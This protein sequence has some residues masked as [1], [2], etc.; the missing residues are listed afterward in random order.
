MTSA[1]PLLRRLVNY[2]WA[3]FEQR[4]ARAYVAG[5]DREQALRV[6]E[7]LQQRAGGTV[8]LWNSGEQ[9]PVEIARECRST[10]DAIR[11][12]SLDC[13]LSIKAPALGF[14]RL[15]VATIVAEGQRAR[16]PIHFDA[17]RWELADRTFS[18]ISEVA[19][20]GSQ[21]GCTLPGRWRRSVSDSRLASELGLRVRVVK[22]QSPDGERSSV[23]A[24][25]G[26]L[27]V[28]DALAG[29]VPLV[30]V[31]THDLELSR[32]ALLRLRAAGTR[33]E[34]ELLY[35][36]PLTASFQQAKSLGVPVR[37][38]VP[39]GE[40]AVPYHFSDLRRDPRILSWM[41]QDL[42]GKTRKLRLRMLDGNP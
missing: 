1:H 20:L 25:Q 9:S 22:G 37:L 17:Q 21:L 40:A 2:S 38:Y 6:C 29:K 4:A 8:C 13:R 5:P 41:A 14:S 36:L 28:I 31:A 39:Y 3:L 27:Q 23:D 30:A 19:A 16:V 15:L 26:F 24:R 32:A 34:L 12:R 18:L 10:V 42:A 33:S 35:G 7:R 11:L